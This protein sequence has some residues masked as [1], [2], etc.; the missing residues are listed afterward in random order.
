MGQLRGGSGGGGMQ[1]NPLDSEAFVAT[2]FP[3]RFASIREIQAGRLPTDH[4][5]Y[6]RYEVI[7]YEMQEQGGLRIVTYTL[8]IAGAG[9]TGVDSSP[10]EADTFRVKVTFLSENGYPPEQVLPVKGS[11]SYVQDGQG[12][13][14]WVYI[15]TQAQER[16]DSRFNLKTPHYAPTTATEMIEAEGVGKARV[17]LTSDNRY[18]VTL[19]TYLFHKG[20][21]RDYMML[22]GTIKPK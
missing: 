8:R 7:E 4:R 17:S 14:Q 16:Y 9:V 5:E 21:R 18:M 11:P 19:T 2:S 3:R 12:A 6:R 1:N 20:N 13:K 22:A 10:K 15:E